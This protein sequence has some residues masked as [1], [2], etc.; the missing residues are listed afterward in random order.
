MQRCFIPARY[1][2]DKT[3]SMSQPCRVPAGFRNRWKTTEQIA[4]H[5]TKTIFDRFRFFFDDQSFGGGGH[6][7]NRTGVHGFAVR[8]EVFS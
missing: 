3:G 6:G 5:A 4:T 7:R 2:G 8:R 1:A